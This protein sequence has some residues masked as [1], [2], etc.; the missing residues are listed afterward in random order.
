MNTKK[1]SKKMTQRLLPICFMLVALLLLNFS[2][3]AQDGCMMVPLSLNQRVQQ[4]TVIVEGKVISQESFWGTGRRNIFTRSTVQVY[5]VFKGDYSSATIEIITQGGQVGDVGQALSSEI[6]LH[7]GD[8]GVLTCIRS[9][10]AEAGRTGYTPYGSMQGFIMYDTDNGS[11]HDPFKIYDGIENELHPLIKGI[12]KRAAI[13]IAPNPYLETLRRRGGGINNQN[14]NRSILAT[15]TITSF[16]PTSISSGTSSN[17]TITGTNFGATQGSGFVEFKNANDG[18]GTYIK[19]LTTDYVSWSNTQIV[20]KVPSV[21]QSGPGAGTGTIKV[22]NSDASSNV[23]TS[24]G[25]LTITYAYSNY[26][27]DNYARI[28]THITDNSFG[29]YTFTMNT[30]FATN[31]TAANKMRA[32]LN[33]WTCASGMNWLLDSS[34]TAVAAVASDGI[35]VMTFVPSLSA[36]VLASCSSWYYTCGTGATSSAYVGE[37]DVVISSAFTWYYGVSTTVP[38]GQYDFESVMLHEMG[39]GHQLNHS[40]DPTAVMHYSI[41]SAQAKRT[42]NANENAGAIF[43]KNQ[44]I[45]IGTVCGSALPMTV[46][47]CNAGTSAPIVTFTAN[48]TSVIAGCSV[49]FSAEASPEVTSWSWN[50]GGGAPNSTS[51]NPNVTFNTPGTYSVTLTATNAYGATPFTR[52]SYIVVTTPTCSTTNT[53]FIGNLADYSVTGGKLAGHNGAGELA[54]ADKFTYCGNPTTLT[55]LKLY[56]NLQTGTGSIIAKVWSADGVGGIPGTVL[57]SQTVAISAITDYPGATTVTLPSP[58]TLTGDYY[59]GYQIVYSGTDAVS[60]LTNSQGESPVST[61]TRMSSGGVWTTYLASYGL[62]LSLKVEG[63]FNNTPTA[64]ITP[65]SA[66]TFCSGGSVTLNANTNSAYTYLW[67]KNTVSLGITT[68]S[69]SA[70][71]AGNYTVQ[72]S[73]GTCSTTSAT[74]VVTVNSCNNANLSN[75]TTSTGTLAPAFASGTIAYTVAVPNATSSMTVTPTVSDAA[76]TVKVN[77]VTVASGSASGSIALVVG[78]NTITT[79]VTAQD[80]I[81]TKTYTITVTR[82]GSAIATLSNLVVSTGTLAPVF[83]SATIAYTLT[84]PNATSSMTVTPTVSDANATIK[85]NTI[86]VASGSAS[87]AI[88]LSVGN[89]IIST[90]VTAQDG[91]TTVTYTITVTRAA[92]SN[93][94]LSNL[95]VSTG[96]LAPV[97]ASGTIA[98]TLSVPFSTSSMTVTPTVTDAAAT[99]KVNTVTVA[100]GS[101]SGSLALAVGSNTV[102]T[103]VTAQDGTT[104]KTY[105]ITVTRAA[106]STNANLSNLVPSTGTLAPVFGAATTAYTIS[107]ANTTSSLTI[108]PTV[109]DATATVKVNGVTV[110]SGSPSGSITLN[111]GTNTVTTIVT[112]QDGTTTKSYVITVTRAGSNNANLSN[113]VVSTGTLAPVFATGTIAYTMSVPNTTSSMTVTPTVADATATVTVN[114]V[115]VTS[116]SASG[117]IALAVGNNTITT[118][119]TAQDGTTIKTYTITVTRAG[120][121]NAN[122]SNLA[123]STGTLAPVFASGTIAYT[124]SVPFTT[125]SMTVTPTVTDATATIKVNTVTVATGVASG[126]IALAVGSNTIT[127]VVTAQDGT[128]TKTYTITV[129]RTAA[130][131][132]ANLSN[133]VVSTGTLAPVFAAATIA[134]TMSVANATSSMTVTPTVADATATITVNSVAVTSGAASGSIALAIGSNTITTIVTAQNGTTKTYTITVNRAGSNNANLS[135]LIVSTG[136][137]APVFA[138]GT[139]TYTMSV[140][141]TTSSMT[142][143]PTVSDATATIKVNTITVAS[144][145]VSGLIALAVGSNTLT[146]VVTAQ[147]GTTTKTYTIT[148]TRAAASTNANLSNLVV[149]TGTLSPVFSSATVGYTM[150]VPNATS[151]MTVTPTVA[152]V[153]ATVKVNTVTVTSGSASGPIA[154]A[155]GSNTITTVVTAQNGTTK[156]Y[157]ITVTRAA[158]GG[159][160][161][162]NL[163]LFIEGYYVPSDAAMTSVMFNQDGLSPTGDVGIVTVELHHATTYALVASATAM[164]HVNGSVSASFSSAISGSF[165]IAVKGNNFIQTWS[166]NPQTVGAAPLN[167][168]FTTS[169]SQAYGSNMVNVGGAWAFYSGDITQDEL[170][171]FSDYS[172]WEIDAFNFAFGVYTTDLNGDGLVEFS[173]Y[174]IWETNANKFIFANYPF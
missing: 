119:V 147:D 137:L 123:V 114:T 151:T 146:T 29:G 54:F 87:G 15:P 159:A 118:V 106:G 66:T 25:T 19:P 31:T 169:A 46:L 168:S 27:K 4:S 80:G 52:S 120:S 58:L 113:L 112:A 100:S 53:N 125:T 6:T 115:A 36:G 107:V 157:T 79:I 103:V 134:Y 166:A 34:T 96:T 126:A 117:T 33:T 72:V 122:L 61:A 136:T 167:Y 98:Y 154:L 132:N 95:V 142:L 12:T 135:N 65:A 50:F 60:L 89:N 37:I 108:T 30:S 40:V 101:A 17:L 155:V 170:I 44:D 47:A 20:V 92:S 138:T 8:M 77:G 109:S 111:V 2:A 91:T 73:Y 26:N 35:N 75:L 83:A 22:T 129:T 49:S 93:A 145:S 163:T 86:T 133:L 124:M 82:A 81:T 85:V 116:G 153:T 150:S 144:G 143:T 102:T 64:T 18:G 156:T 23:V 7:I 11:A 16:S 59:I 68:S 161:L 48:R 10:Y 51:Q 140:P 70:T 84:V 28:P 162:V 165:Y 127:T 1:D 62:S 56:F 5:K 128:T 3:R 173:D 41:S 39:H 32:I 45:G 88:A 152:D 67:Y 69:Y 63:I 42:L 24:A 43:I 160:S 90:V 38:A 78:S 141:F 99:I 139:I 149:S 148:V 121:A 110:T 172:L 9:P 74:T 171:E 76:A 130:S 174:G 104:T 94:N 71:T 97:F 55:Q 158:A 105:T 131:T 57:S 164:L 13:I 14:N 21:S